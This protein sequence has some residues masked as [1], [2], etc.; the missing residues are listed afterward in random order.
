MRDLILNFED[1]LQFAVI[2]LSPNR[3]AVAG[4]SELGGDSQATAGA[5]NAT[6]EDVGGAELLADLRGRQW[7]VPKGEHGGAREEAKF[8]D[9]RELGDDVLGHAVAK[10]FVLFVPAEI[11]EIE[12][13]ERFFLAQSG[14]GSAAESVEDF[15]HRGAALVGGFHQA[16]VDELLPLRR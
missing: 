1:I 4:F 15:A 3:V 11:C 7:F 9:F 5:P 2:P 8:L 16:A 6:V 13:G 14:R 12:Y 10:V